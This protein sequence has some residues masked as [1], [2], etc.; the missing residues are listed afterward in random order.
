MLDIS[1]RWPSCLHPSGKEQARWV[2]P[3]DL[4][5][6]KTKGT[7]H[8]QGLPPRRL[9]HTPSSAPPSNPAPLGTPQP[10]SSKCDWP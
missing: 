1:Q 2:R 4:P 5:L 7:A 8:K 3:E 10:N 9:L 6:A